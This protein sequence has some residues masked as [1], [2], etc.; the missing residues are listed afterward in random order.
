MGSRSSLA[1]QW[2]RLRIL[3]QI[4]GEVVMGELVAA[5]AIDIL[6]LIERPLDLKLREP[7]IIIIIITIIICT[8]EIDVLYIFDDRFPSK[9]FKNKNLENLKYYFF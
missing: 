8:S 3:L 9:N 7:L 4:Q 2:S 5:V 6:R 1:Q